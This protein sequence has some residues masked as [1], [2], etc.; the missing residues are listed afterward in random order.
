MTLVKW[1]CRRGF[2]LVEVAF[3]LGVVSFSMV[4][5]L[6]ILSFGLNESLAGLHETRSTHL[7]QAVFAAL[8]TPPF[9]AVDCFGKTLDLSAMDDADGPVVLYAAFPVAEPPAIRAAPDADS[10]CTLELHFHKIAGAG[11]DFSAIPA[12]NRVTL[13]IVPKNKAETPVRFASI[14]GNY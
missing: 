9:N 14:V 10:T 3:S 6:G 12:G 11:L 13:T 4:A 1:G 8:R 7:A 2:S 5:M